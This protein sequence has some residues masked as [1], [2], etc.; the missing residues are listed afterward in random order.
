MTIL[1][2]ITSPIWALS[3]NGFGTVVQG[4]AAIRQ[5]IF[6]TL[7]TSMGSDPLRP[8]FGTQIY[9]YQ[10]APVNVAAVEIKKQIIAGLQAWMSDDIENVKVT[11]TIQ[12][13]SH[14][15]FNIGY[16]L[17]NSE[18]YDNLQYELDN[19]VLTNVTNQALT[20]QA[21]IPA[22]PTGLSYLL[23]LVL[24]NNAVNPPAPANGFDSIDLLYNWIK[25][26]W[27][28]LGKW[29][30]QP[31]QIIGYISDV[32]Y[33]TGK[34]AITL[35]NE[36][37]I[38]ATI[39]VLNP[40]EKWIVRFQPDPAGTNFLAD[41]P[42]YTM[43]DIVAGMQSQFGDY[44]VWYLDNV[45]GDFNADFNGD[46]NVSSTRLVLQTKDYPNAVVT[47]TKA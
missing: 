33:L 11:Y 1:S 18:L 13:N 22:N 32:K 9:L 7:T 42:F 5:R 25:S 39:P 28:F 40:G 45:N 4:I 12:D 24:N 10:D 46:F 3:I 17:V 6:I 26:N 23:S 15:I 34:L 47:I 37:K 41:N 30:Q 8:L 27:S 16:E 31:D 21:L 35:L 19:G 43:A 44:G 20:L 38:Y 36:F 14:V 29:L 2:K